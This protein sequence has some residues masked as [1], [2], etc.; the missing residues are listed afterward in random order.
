VQYVVLGLAGKKAKQL[1]ISV[2]YKIRRPGP[3]QQVLWQEPATCRA[4]CLVH[5]GTFSLWSSFLSCLSECSRAVG[6]GVCAVQVGSAIGAF[7][8]KF[9]DA[10][11]PY[12]EGLMPQVRGFGGCLASH[13]QPA[14]KDC[15]D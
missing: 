10:V 2:D 14:S 1:F 15:L 6:L 8:K 5:S 11:L 9:G 13:M 12:V 7:L 4:V 3:T